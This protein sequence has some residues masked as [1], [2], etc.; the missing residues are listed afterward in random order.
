MTII[1]RVR[2]PLLVI[3]LYR[4]TPGFSAVAEIVT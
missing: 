1:L 4:Y 3:S 2:K